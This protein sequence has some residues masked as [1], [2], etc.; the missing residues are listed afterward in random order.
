MNLNDYEAI[1]KRQELP[2]GTDADLTDLRQ[3]FEA[4]RRKMER[5][6]LL[7]NFIEGAGG[8]LASAGFGLLTWKQGIIGWP[9]IVGLMLIAGVS[10]VFLYDGWRFQR[11]RPGPEAPILAKLDATIAE[12]RHQRGFISHYGKWYLTSYGTAILL[13]GYGF[14]QQ[15]RRGAPPEFLVTLLTTPVTAAWIAILLIVPVAATV[16]WWLDV[17][18]TIRQRID[19]RLAELEKLRAAMLF[20]DH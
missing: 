6:I 17:Q 12:L 4:K 16:W 11:A 13:I 3:T 20:S 8:I 2:R 10:C 19:P 7:R 5:T 18:K 15:M 14:L 1:W 9:V